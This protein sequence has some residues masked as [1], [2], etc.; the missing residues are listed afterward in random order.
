MCFVQVATVVVP[1]EVDS[2]GYGKV[3][4]DFFLILLLLSLF[5][6]SLCLTLLYISDYM[7]TQLLVLYYS[8]SSIRDGCSSLAMFFS[9][10]L[11]ISFLFFSSTC[12]FVPPS[13]L[14]PY[15]TTWM[16]G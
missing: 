9:S 15:P 11:Y 6:I 1:M 4:L 7:Y 14:K 2:S 5:H 10:S 13:F 16:V 12:T 8:D 3:R